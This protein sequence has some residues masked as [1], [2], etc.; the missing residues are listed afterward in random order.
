LIKDVY[1]ALRASSNWNKTLFIIT[2]DEHGGYYDHVPTPLANV[3]SPDG[4]IGIKGEK[5]EG[6]KFDRL[7]I[8]V[9]T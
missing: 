1:E 4:I 2:Y 6:F 5:G 8:R 7:G 9:P 3:P